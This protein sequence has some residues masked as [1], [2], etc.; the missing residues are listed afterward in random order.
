MYQILKKASRLMRKVS[1]KAASQAFVEIPEF[2]D[3][4][5][6]GIESRRPLEQFQMLG[7]ALDAQANQLD[8]WREKTIQYLLRPLV[9]EDEG[10][11]ITGDEYE[12]STKTQ[13]EVMVYI[14]ALR[15][16]IEDRFDAL[17]GQDNILIKGDVRTALKLAKDGEGAFPEKVIELYKTRKAVKPTRDMSSLRGIFSELRSISTTLKTD[18][19]N[20]NSRAMHEL[21]ILEPE[22]VK[23]QKQ[24]TDQTKAVV[25]LRQEVELF[26]SVMNARLEYYRQLQQVS[27]MVALLEERDKSQEAYDNMTKEEEKLENKLAMAV[28]KRRYLMHLHDEA[29]HSKEQRT[30]I[31]CQETFEIGALTVCGHQFCKDCILL[32]RQ[33]HPSCPVCKRKLKTQD[34]YDITYK[35]QQLKVAE[36]SIQNSSERE[37][38]AGMIQSAI[39]SNISNNTLTQIQNVELDGPSYTTKIDT[40]ARHLIWLRESDPGSKS[41]IF[42]QFKEFLDVLSRALTTYHIGHT[43]I[44]KPR[45]TER[46][47]VD[48]GIECFL[49]HAKSQSSGLNLVNASHVF[50]C[51]PLINTALELQA[52]ARVDRIGQRQK[53]SVYLYLIDGT[54]E[55]NIYA[56]SVRRRAEHMSMG[57]GGSAEQQQKQKAQGNEKEKPMTAELLDSNI[58]AANSLE[59]QQ[60]PLA[61]LLTKGKAGGEVVDKTDLWDCLF[62][63]K[64]RNGAW[65][66]KMHVVGQGGDEERRSERW[67][68]RE[69]VVRGFLGA[70][71]AETR[72]N[73]TRS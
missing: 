32:W 18:A 8:E 42:S 71:A 41:I 62:R 39:Y 34:L 31:I 57:R 73:G 9:D 5:I 46:F 59:L 20:G 2:A 29:G 58:E 52:I 43:S 26:T 72:A 37:R 22:R 67:R 51:E 17:T 27:D 61:N 48:P 36:E 12:E 40:I 4:K 38:S 50:L 33:Q 68:E 53:T 19:E 1:K 69:R 56:I 14:S 35:P 16:V 13:D 24:L 49:L 7:A 44:A 23:V 45:G 66:S 25:A 3:P 64:A 6:S 21:S 65:G 30:C 28:S 10:V 54:V 70:E 55:E 11:E 60:A 63:N 47:K 15:A